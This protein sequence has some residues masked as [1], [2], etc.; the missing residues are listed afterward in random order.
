MIK[1]HPLESLKKVTLSK[2]FDIFEIEV[3]NKS[4][5]IETKLTRIS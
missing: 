1:I 5:N 2:F 4:V 3:K